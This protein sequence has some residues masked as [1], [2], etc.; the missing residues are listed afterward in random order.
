[1]GNDKRINRIILGAV[2][3]VAVVGLIVNFSGGLFDEVSTTGQ[4]VKFDSTKLS[5]TSTSE[6][7]VETTSIKEEFQESV[8]Q[9]EPV[10]TLLGQTCNQVC[11]SKE[12]SSCQFMERHVISKRYDYEYEAYYLEDDKTTI[13][14]C[15][16]VATTAGIALGPEE[17]MS[18]SCW[19]SS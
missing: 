17:E 2:I 9:K 12:Y 7:S 19:C 6:V 8:F 14:E 13:Y 3:L 18:F 10:N 15:S 11:E 16:S 1:M 4:A 5:Q